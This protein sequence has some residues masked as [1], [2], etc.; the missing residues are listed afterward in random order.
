MTADEIA[1]LDA[2]SREFAAVA[3][4]AKRY[5]ALPAIVDDDYPEARHYYEGALRSLIAALKANGRLDR[6]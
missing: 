6:G 3:E 2:Q 5:N 4:L 1:R